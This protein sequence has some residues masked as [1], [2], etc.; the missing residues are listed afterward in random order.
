MTRPTRLFLSLPAAL[1]IVFL[2]SCA[3]SAVKPTTPIPP[4]INAAEAVAALTDSR[5]AINDIRGAVTLK[6]FDEN[7][8]ATNSVTGY[9]AFRYPD[10]VRFTYIGPFGIVLFEALVNETTTILFLPQQLTAYKGKTDTIEGGPFSP[11]LMGIPFRK[12]AGPIFVIEHDGPESTLY[13]ISKRSDR[14]DLVEKIIFDRS[15]MRPTIRESYENGLARYR[16][17]YLTYEAAGGI[18]VPTGITI[19]DLTSG[20]R[21]EITLRD[22]KVNTGITD[23]VFDT[24]VEPPYVEK[25]LDSFVLPDY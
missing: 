18:N 11:E 5:A 2:T 1:A 13:S 9:M 22:Y 16:I 17:T 3:L 7:G 20:S 14:Y 6:T 15:T 12:P 23:E 24:T 4:A 21:L 25:P 19:Q 8:K 10:K